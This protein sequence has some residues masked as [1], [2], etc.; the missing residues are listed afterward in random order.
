MTML[1][2]FIVIA[3]NEEKVISQTLHGIL[4]Q[5]QLSD[6]EIIV[7]DDKSTDKT[8]K[9]VQT[10]SQKNS[11][12]KLIQNER[13]SGRGFSRARGVEVA[14]GE[15]IIFVDADIILPKNWISR[16]MQALSEYDGV[17]G[18]AAPDGDVC[19][20]YR[21]FNL[22]PKVVAHTTDISGGNG[23]FKRIVLQ[24]IHYDPDMRD[25]EDVD[26]TWKLKKVGFK[27]RSLPD[28]VCEHREYK[29]FVTSLRWMYEQGIGANRL[30]V[31]FQQTRLP[32][33][34]FFAFVALLGF[35]LVITY[36]S[37]IG[38][39]L[40]VLYVGIVSAAHMYKKFQITTKTWLN[41]VLATI[42][43]S[44]MIAAYLFGR[45]LSVGI[46]LRSFKRV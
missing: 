6:F 36:W 2:S 31:R 40:P 44:S 34:T 42:V 23:I 30:L 46:L 38:L 19:Y 35:T 24:S 9:I 25:G 33:I 17:G 32:D 7:I 28:L 15:Y 45:L 10:L 14:K 39:L 11:Q 12:I 4:R 8:A 18:I 27:T 5:D 43:N 41:F 26:M 37:P 29:T 21:I 16:C 3:F 22:R 13:N 1:L 20:V